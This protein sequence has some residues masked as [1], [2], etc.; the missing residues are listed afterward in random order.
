MARFENFRMWRGR[1]PHWRADHETYFVTFRYR[2]PLSDAERT[3]LIRAL[4]TTS[5]RGLE[6]HAIAV[7]AE[8]AQLIFEVAKNDLEL[9]DS[10][11]A[12][13][14]KAGKQ[15]I[16]GTGERFPPFYAESFDR[17]IRDEAEYETL[18]LTLVDLPVAAEEVDD[19]SDSP[20]VWVRES[21][22]A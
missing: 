15:I 12:A 7:M 10:I 9:S 22:D 14:R 16:K 2:R 4:L 6:L 5:R 13:K 3:L 18:W 19:P 1:L 8:E 11:E 20:F 17:I 21:P